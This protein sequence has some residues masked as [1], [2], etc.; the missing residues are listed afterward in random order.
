MKSLNHLLH[1]AQSIGLRTGLDVVAWPLRRA[2]IAARFASPRRR[3]PALW[4]E[5]W[6]QL[7]TTPAALPPLR[8]YDQVT[9]YHSHSICGQTVTI[10]FDSANLLV[11]V[12]ASDVVRLQLQRAGDAADTLSYAVAKA[13]RDWSPV[14]FAVSH[15]AA[16]IEIATEQLVCSIHTSPCRLTFLDPWRGGAPV[17]ANMQPLTCGASVAVTMDLPDDE[18]IYGLGEK[19]SGLDRRGRVYE[20]WNGDPN[21][22]YGQGKDPLYLS[23]PFFMGL[24]SDAAYGMF[25]D[26][27]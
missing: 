6:R 8:E 2:L 16:R 5:A 22:A 15:T 12:L 18:H 27:T 14:P 4:R 10:T 11:T 19:A 23:L 1:A 24:R 7:R 20:M 26:N 17:C 3:G 21:G 9:G 25:F 13:D